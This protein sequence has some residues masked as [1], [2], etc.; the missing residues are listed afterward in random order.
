MQYVMRHPGKAEA[1][2]LHCGMHTSSP[3]VLRLFMYDQSAQ[4][5]A[6]I[7]STVVPESVVMIFLTLCGHR[8]CRCRSWQA[9][10]TAAPCDGGARR[11]A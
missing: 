4:S 11:S 1:G 9:G 7:H 2:T 3:V 6:L 10:G 5:S 8:W